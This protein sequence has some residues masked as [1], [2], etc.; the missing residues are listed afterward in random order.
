VCDRARI[1][2][3]PGTAFAGASH[4]LEDSI[5]LLK[6]HRRDETQRKQGSNKH[7]F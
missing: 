6:P 1:V 7:R 3:P 4:A 2:T 5:T